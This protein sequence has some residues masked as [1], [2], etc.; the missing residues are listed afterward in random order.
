MD[1]LASLR[2]KMI[3]K[4]DLLNLNA[5][6]EKLPETW[7]QITNENPIIQISEP[8][9]LSS[10]SRQRAYISDKKIKNNCIDFTF[11]FLI[12]DT[13]AFCA[14]FSVPIK[15]ESVEGVVYAHLSE[16]DRKVSINTD[17][18]EAL[19]KSIIVYSESN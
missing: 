16:G 4:N 7:F 5:K 15:Y 17:A 8:G 13:D 12:G 9:F 14:E 11:N 3:S 19:V 2:V 6:V 18:K 1:I 10:D